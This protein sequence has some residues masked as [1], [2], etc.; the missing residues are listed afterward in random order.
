MMVIIIMMMYYLQAPKSEYVPYP[1]YQMVAK[2]RREK[3]K[4]L[5]EEV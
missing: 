5:D 1:H 3:E 2:A 4:R